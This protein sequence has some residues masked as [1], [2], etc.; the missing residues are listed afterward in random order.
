[1]NISRDNKIK[2][3]SAV[4][5]VF[6][7]WFGFGES[8]ADITKCE[9][10]VTKYVTA[11]FSEFVTGIDM[12]GDVYTELDSWSDAASL[13]FITV[14]VD[15]YLESNSHNFNVNELSG[16]FSPPMPEHNIKAKR[17][18]HFDNFRY[19]NQG[20]L[21]I[22][23]YSNDGYDSF[24]DPIGLTS[25]CISKLQTEIIVKQWYSISYGSEWI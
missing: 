3:A 14:S 18:P 24:N 4:S 20:N 10:T 25:K 19:H 23:T 15:G 12:D 21:K 22:Y 16:Y 9:S 8:K 13:I 6:L 17:E 1:M 7:I 5:V 11:E 2:L